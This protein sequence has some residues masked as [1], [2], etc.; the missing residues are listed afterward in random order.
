MSQDLVRLFNRTPATKIL[1]TSASKV[2]F[3][4]NHSVCLAS[5]RWREGFREWQKPEDSSIA[6]K[7][8][9]ISRNLCEASL[10]WIIQSVLWCKWTK[11]VKH[12]IFKVES[13]LSVAKD[14][15]NRWTDMVFLYS[16]AFYMFWDGFRLLYFINKSG[17][18]FRLFHFPSNIE[19]LD[20]RGVA[21][22][23]LHNRI[24][25]FRS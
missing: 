2:I 25:G 10:T 20:T 5:R 4:S 7:I 15:A 16:E 23:T 8:T 9:R 3:I 13:F 18:G 17:Y 1:Q 12:Y 6:Q 24:T 19:L 14:L 21:V 11:K 22:S